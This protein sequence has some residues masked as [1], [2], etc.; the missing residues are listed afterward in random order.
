MKDEGVESRSSIDD[1]IELY[2][3]DVDRT[4]LRENMKLAVEQRFQQLRNMQE[5]YEEAQRQRARRRK[6]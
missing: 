3:R 6:K 2:K 1:I 4:L 5:F